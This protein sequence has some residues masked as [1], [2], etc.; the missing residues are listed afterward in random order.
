MLKKENQ[1]TIFAIGERLDYDS[2]VKFHSEKDSFS[3]HGFDYVSTNYSRLLS[4]KIPSIKTKKVIIFLF[5]PF[6]YW[7]RYIEYRNYKGLYGNHNF[8][9]KFMRF[10]K[11]VDN[12]IRT[13]LSD[14]EIAFVNSPLLCGFCRD[15]LKVID[16]LSRAHISQPRL[17]NIPH[18]EE[19]Q[20]RLVH[21]YS[22]FI[23]PRYGSMGKGITFLSWSNWQTNF[24]FKNNRIINKRSDRGWRF[25]DITVNDAFLT[26][27]LKKGE[28][29]LIEETIDSLILKGKKVDLRIYTF[30]NKVIYVY[31]RK[32]AP[33][34]ITTNISQGGRGDPK[35]LKM[36]PSHLLLKAKKTAEKISKV[37][38]LNLAGIDIMLDKNLKDAYVVDVNVFS[39]F[40]KRKTFNLT[41]HMIKEL[42]HLNNNGSFCF[43]NSGNI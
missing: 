11:R 30:F 42:A 12:S 10:W 18:L 19:M 13:L 36:L 9:I 17:Y 24:R 15:K 5:F 3:S 2:F 43:E 4:G 22:F 39:G 23:K 34:K 6:I 14:K 16:K 28:D 40:P 41:K 31:P 26:Q 38:N 33:D 21:G 20:K 29:I 32:N 35:A 8:F 25:R 27:L 7:N 37:L 1:I